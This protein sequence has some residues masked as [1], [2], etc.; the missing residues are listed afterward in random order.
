MRSQRLLDDRPGLGCIRRSPP[1]PVDDDL[2]AALTPLSADEA[3]GLGKVSGDA[4]ELGV[5]A[6][7]RPPRPPGRRRRPA[8]IGGPGSAQDI[9]RWDRIDEGDERGQGRRDGEKT[10]PKGAAA[11]SSRSG[12]SKRSRRAHQPA[13]VSGGKNEPGQQEIIPPGHKDLGDFIIDGHSQNRPNIQSPVRFSINNGRE[14]Y[15]DLKSPQFLIRWRMIFVSP[16]ASSWRASYKN[17]FLMTS[18][19]KFQVI[20]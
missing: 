13:R 15:S 18:G 10:R 1:H 8:E 6:A 11:A 14:D 4:D 19:R 20:L 9:R 7:C 17:P 16:I 2:G 5:R 12:P 3:G